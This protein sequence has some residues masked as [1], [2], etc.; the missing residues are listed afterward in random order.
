[1]FLFKRMGD[2]GGID[3]VASA[4]IRWNAFRQCFAEGGVGAVIPLFFG[5]LGMIVD[6]VARQ[7]AEPPPSI[8]PVQPPS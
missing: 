6:R 8:P 1:M 5:S 3:D 4:S 7:R 2:T